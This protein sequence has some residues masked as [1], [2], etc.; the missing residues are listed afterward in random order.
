LRRTWL[1]A[2]WVYPSRFL[3]L[4]GENAAVATLPALSAA[5]TRAAEALWPRLLTWLRSFTSAAGRSGVLPG[6]R[7][8][9][10]QLHDRLSA[11]WPQSVIADYPALAQ[12][13][14]ARVQVPDFWQPQV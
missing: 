11:R 3:G 14:A 7:V 4:A 5:E 12:P 10:G 13:G 8:L 6:L 1:C 9:A 2:A